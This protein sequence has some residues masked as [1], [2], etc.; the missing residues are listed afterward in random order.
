MTILLL[1]DS[2]LFEKLEI[3]Y[4]ARM[5][6][7]QCTNHCLSQLQWMR[8]SADILLQEQAGIL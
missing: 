7:H 4:T 6:T 5:R 1:L 3:V 2:N 8:S